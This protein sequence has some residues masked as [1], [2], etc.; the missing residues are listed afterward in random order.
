MRKARRLRL[1]LLLAV[2][3]AQALAAA[4]AASTPPAISFTGKPVRSTRPGVSI[5]PL[6][7]LHGGLGETGKAVTVAFV[8]LVDGSSG[9]QVK[10][11]VATVPLDASGAFRGSF[12]DVVQ[13]RGIYPGQ[14]IRLSAT[15]DNGTG[16]PEDRLDDIALSPVQDGG[17]PPAAGDYSMTSTWNALLGPKQFQYEDLWTVRL[18]VEGRGSSRT[19]SVTYLGP[20][21]NFASIPIPLERGVFSGMAM[22]VG[23]D[24]RPVESRESVR[25]SGAFLPVDENKFVWKYYYSC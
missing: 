19:V 1:F 21:G 13:L 8:Y 22:A 20:S 11:P 2:G 7:W 12:G 15:V 25:F 6:A 16:I 24:G 5:L 9:E 14:Q 3:A 17:D 18:R 4:A 10:M 23:E